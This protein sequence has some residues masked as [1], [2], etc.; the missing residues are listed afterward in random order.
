MTISEKQTR[1]NIINQQLLRA[2]W[3]VNNPKNVKKEFRIKKEDGYEYADYALL[4]RDGSVLAIVEAKKTAVDVDQGREQ[5]KQYC[6]HYQQSTNNSL[7]FCFYTN[8]DKI[9]FWQLDEY[10]PRKVYGYPTYDDLERLHALRKNKEELSLLQQPINTDIAGRDYQLGAI[11]SIF[12]K[13]EQK[14]RHFLLVMATGTGKTRTAIAL[15]EALT[16]AG[17]ARQILFLV[18]RIALREQALDAFKEHLPEYSRWPNRGEAV[19]TQGRRI[20][21]STYPTM[22]NIIEDDYFSLSPHFFDFIVVDESHRSIYNRYQEILNYFDAPLLG[23]TAT[24]KDV[25][26]FNTYQLFECE[27]GLPTFAYTY[28]DAVNNNPPY[29]ADFEVMRVRTNFQKE[30]I[31]QRTVSLEDQ[32]RLLLEGKEVEE[33][34]FEGSDLERLVTN[35]GTNNS[36]IQEFMESSIKD[37]NGVIPGKS[38]FFCST[39]KHAR[40]VEKLFDELYPQYKGELARVIVSDDPRVYGKGGLLDQFKHQDMPRIAISVDMLDTGIDVREIVNLVFAKPVYSYTKFWQMIGRGTRLLEQTKIKAWCREKDRFLIIDCW[41]NFEYFKLTPKGRESKQHRSL[42]VQWI[43]ARIDKIKAAMQESEDEIAEKE[44]E[45]LLHNIALLPQQSVTIQDAS[46][47]LREISQSQYWKNLTEAKFAFLRE[48]IAPLF[49]V[50]S[51]DDYD[52]MRFERDLLRFSVACF[53]ENI[54]NLTKEKLNIISSISRLPMTIPYVKQQ[55]K[56]IFLVQQ[57]AFWSDVD[58]EKLTILCDN[59]GPLMRFKERDDQNKTEVSLNLTD[60]V[61]IKEWTDFSL[62][63]ASL[64]V[65]AYKEKVNAHLKELVD[66]TPLLQKIKLSE[67]LDEEEL[68]QLTEVLEADPLE[69]TEAKL[70]YVYAEQKADLQALIRHCL[71]VESLTMRKERFEQIINA[72]FD[73]YSQ[74]HTTLSPQ[75]RRFI[76]LLKQSFMDRGEI[77]RRELISAPFTQIHPTGIRGVFEPDEIDQILKITD[78]LQEKLN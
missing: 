72:A 13:L 45:N 58:D 22:K 61:V 12:A 44:I 77:T 46:K 43:N 34:N 78:Q 5:A 37:H 6:I 2:G 7:P 69:I 76:E 39:I 42:P 73:Q 54:A 18:D 1:N 21:V 65:E 14:K 57:E 19:I 15:I 64:S 24:P 67:K 28:E 59:L 16:K 29:L 66:Q 56:L 11:T 55:E 52:A 27:N 41:D 10:P 26:D 38:I 25:I 63:N 3:D 74:M 9:Y 4:K 70:R 50:Y 23:L 49:D 51:S 17:Y 60:S 62:R 33:I 8:G 47:A 36:I 20:Y 48:E 40:R 32:K 71:G 68:H 30:G 31:N 75:Q 35:K 53:Q